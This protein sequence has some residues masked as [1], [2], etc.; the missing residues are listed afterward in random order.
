MDEFGSAPAGAAPRIRTRELRAIAM[1]I[2]IL[3]NMLGVLPL[4]ITK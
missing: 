2:S 4:S 1:P 3:V